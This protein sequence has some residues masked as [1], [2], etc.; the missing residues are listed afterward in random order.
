MRAT[1]AGMSRPSV[2]VRAEAAA[3]IARL[4]GPDRTKEVEDGLRRWLAEDPEH[5][6]AFE[7]LT[8]VWEKAAHLSRARIRPTTTPRRVRAR[9]RMARA[10]LAAVVIALV[11]VSDLHRPSTRL[12]ATGIDQLRTVVL[13]DGTRI[14]LDADTRLLVRYG[15]QS[16]HVVLMKG[17][18]Y[19]AVA[20]RADR[21]FIVTAAGHAIRDIGTQFDVQRD[22]NVLAVTLVEGEVTVSAQPAML[23]SIRETSAAAPHAGPLRSPSP[24]SDARAV[25][26]APGERL[27]F[28]G[29]GPPKIDWPAVTRVTAWERGEVPLENISLAEAAAELNRYSRQ[30]IVIHDPAVGAIRVSGIVQAGASSSFAAAVAKAYHLRVLRPSR[31]T[32]VL[33]PGR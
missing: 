29:P 10:A 17:Q 28:N 31:D 3:W 8:D 2:A 1:H 33:V 20:H 26:L 14:R 21:P 4:H 32:I 19:F 5:T 13:A 18:A 24:T 23:R 25:T 16:R 11:M 30:R 9:V 6:A 7:L 22:G 27:T 12:I 15:R